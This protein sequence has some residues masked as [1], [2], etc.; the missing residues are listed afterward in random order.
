MMS[1]FRMSPPPALIGPRDEN[2]AVNGAA[3]SYTIVPFEIAAV[4]PAAAAALISSRCGH[5]VTAGSPLVTQSPERWIVG[6]RCRSALIEFGL[7]LT[8][9]IPIPPAS[10]TARLL[11][12]R[13]LPPR[14]QTTILPAIFAGS[15]TGFST[16]A[17][18]SESE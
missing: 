9:I 6:T 7:V 3:A 12:V 17:E 13:P 2:D 10:L 15:S 18:S 16:S 4:L 11:S 5:V 8:R 14:S 1:G